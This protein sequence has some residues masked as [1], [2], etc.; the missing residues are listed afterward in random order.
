MMND[1]RCG[2]CSKKLGMGIYQTLQI[3]CPRCNTLNFLRAES[4]KPEH[5]ECHCK[6]DTHENLPKSQRNPT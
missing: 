3:K 1:I 5:H 2:A 6:S 4:P